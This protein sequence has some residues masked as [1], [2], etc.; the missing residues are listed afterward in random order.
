VAADGGVNKIAARGEMMKNK[1]VACAESD[2]SP[3]MKRI[4]SGAIDKQEDGGRRY[5][6]AVPW[7]DSSRLA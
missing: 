1:C 6:H 4:I 2:A 7:H 3:R 5:R